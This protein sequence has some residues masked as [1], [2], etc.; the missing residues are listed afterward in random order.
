MK[1]TAAL[2][3]FGQSLW[4]DNITR[5]LLDDGTLKR[6]IDQFSVTGLTSNPTIF[7]HAIGGGDA[8]DAD[9]FAAPPGRDTEDLFVAMAL[10]DLGRAADLFG[11][12]HKASGG[13]D[14]WVSME[15][16]PLLAEDAPGT[17]AAA[18]ALHHQGARANLFI[19]IPGTKAGVAAIEEA[20]FA[21]IPVNVTLLFSAAQTIDA[22]EARMRGIAR[23]IEAGLDPHIQSVLSLF[24]SRWDV[25]VADKVPADLR[26]RLGI[27]V[28]SQ[29]LRAYDKLL[30]RAQW[31]ELADAGAP[32]QRLLWASTGTKDPAASDV[33]YIEALAAKGT[34]NTIPEGTLHAFA[35]HGRVGQGIAADGGDCDAVITGFR[36][37]GIDTDA[38]A[39][40]LQAEGAEAFVKSWQQLMQGIDQKRKVDPS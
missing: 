32:V 9:I 24:I 21:G 13:A 40:R 10:A 26:N 17:V 37:A 5:T 1:P 28:A 2:H 22:A 11:P 39:A 35:D 38:L 23:R 25:A 19:K 6:Y 27:A 15:V 31:R 34:I 30:A 18:K 12:A 29:T 8:Y 14:G 16:S 4:L 33:L 3:A 36:Q 20:T 7:Q